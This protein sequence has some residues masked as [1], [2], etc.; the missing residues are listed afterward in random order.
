M[1]V[2]PILDKWGGGSCEYFYL[3]PIILYRQT[4]FEPLRKW[5][6]GKSSLEVTVA[7]LQE[8]GAKTFLDASVCG[9]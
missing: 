8:A 5:T 9:A 6:V 4:L 2:Q 1:W 3:T 7:A